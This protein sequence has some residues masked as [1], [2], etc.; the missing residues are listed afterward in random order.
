M[1]SSDKGRVEG[2]QAV[3]TSIEDLWMHSKNFSLSFI[4][5]DGKRNCIKFPLTDASEENEGSSHGDI[6]LD[7]VLLL[8]RG[9]GIDIGDR[10]S[11]KSLG[12]IISSIPSL[13]QISV[14]SV[15][16]SIDR[17]S[18]DTKDTVGCACVGTIMYNLVSKHFG[19]LAG[20]VRETRSILENFA[21]HNMIAKS[22][23]GVM[24]K[25]AS[26]S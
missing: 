1:F 9:D 11:L 4:N 21:P 14:E 26:S 6:L 24:D 16:T 18:I 20:F 22:A 15:V 17:A 5:Q 19:K 13:Y 23:L 10:D 2:N 3:D 25:N 7:K 12:S 8:M